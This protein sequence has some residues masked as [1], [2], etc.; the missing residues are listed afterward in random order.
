MKQLIVNADDFG[1]TEGV[2]RGIVEAHADGIVTS[3]TILANGAAFEAAVAMSRKLP[4]LAIGVHL[5]LTQGPP[6]APPESVQALIDAR[7]ELHLS[8]SQLWRAIAMRRV[9]A[10]QI[11]TELRAQV[12]KVLAAGLTP[13]HLD[14]HMHVHLF[15]VV[16]DAAI[17]IAGE[18]GM[19]AVRC[20]LERTRLKGLGKG[21]E[22][23]KRGGIA[24]SVSQLAR[25]L[26]SKLEK[27]G[28]AYPSHFFGT[29]QTGSLDRESLLEI[30]ESLPDGT[31]ELCCHP[32]YSNADLEKAGG[33]LTF[34]REDELLALTS[35]EAKALI[36]SRA[37]RLTTYRALAQPAS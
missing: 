15:P 28:L 23:I 32:G 25:R 9:P 4:S 5:N 6:V 27:A 22:E 36:H 10:L 14:G 16:S 11:E 2:N 31:S 8:P 34:Q 30:L 29:R 12:K 37:I 18:F 24:F 1:L 7:G 3:T 21:L 20:P 17:Q 33:E 19:R 26:R 35:V 13:T